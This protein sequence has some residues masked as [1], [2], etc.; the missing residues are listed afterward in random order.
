LEFLCDA[1]PTIRVQDL[2][3]EAFGL[4]EAGS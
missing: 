4:L 1:V 3:D 2:Q